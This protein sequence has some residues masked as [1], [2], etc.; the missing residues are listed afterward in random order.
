[1]I[2]GGNTICH[3]YSGEKISPICE[4]TAAKTHIKSKN[5]IDVANI[6]RSICT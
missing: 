3:G 5:D 6:V 2:A 1:M 4:F